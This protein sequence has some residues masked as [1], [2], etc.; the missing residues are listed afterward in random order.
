[1]SGEALRQVALT[2]NKYPSKSVRK[3]S[4]ELQIPKTTMWQ[5]V[6]RRVRIKLSKFAMIHNVEREDCP[7]RETFCEILLTEMDND[8]INQQRLVFSGETILY[9]QRQS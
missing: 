8:E 5:V 7:K 3:S 1:V 2:F 4:W 9:C 6:C